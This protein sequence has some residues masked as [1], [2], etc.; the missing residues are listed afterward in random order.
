MKIDVFAICYNEEIILPYFFRHYSKFAR[1]ITIYDNMSTDNSVNLIKSFGAKLVEWET[2]DKLD[3]FEFLRVKNNCWKDSDADWVIV[4][5]V[6]EF[7]YHPNIVE[8]LEK[9]EASLIHP[10]AYEMMSENLPNGNGDIY[11][12][13]KMGYS[14]DEFA[15]LGV[16][17]HWKSNYSKGCVFKPKEIQEINFGPG[18]HT[19]SPIGNVKV[20]KNTGL[21]FLHFKYINRE[22]LIK[23]YQDYRIRQS[24]RNI[25]HGFGNYEWDTYEINKQFDSWWPICENIID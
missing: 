12:E 1:N 16:Y 4:V 17:P 23:K 19:C 20:D 18:C 13:I 24:Q 25:N 5:D 8:I 14:M 7:V 9:S 3:E 2:N 22:Y 15:S 10:K 21:K 11:E 6:D